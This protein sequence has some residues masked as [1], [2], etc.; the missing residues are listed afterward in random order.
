MFQKPFKYVA[1][2]DGDL[3]FPT[4]TRTTSLPNIKHLKFLPFRRL[5]S[6]YIVQMCIPRIQA[7]QVFPSKSH[8][9]CIMKY[10]QCNLLSPLTQSHCD[11]LHGGYSK[12]SVCIFASCLGQLAPN[13]EELL[14]LSKAESP[15]DRPQQI[16]R[17]GQP[18]T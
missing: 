16:K 8:K 13:W 18:P 7:I 11:K 6:M 15:A 12:L 17:D 4:T 3:S 1:A 9:P 14:T 2:L 10:E 5:C